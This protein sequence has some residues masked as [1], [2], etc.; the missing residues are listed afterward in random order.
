MSAATIILIFL[1]VAGAVA[2]VIAVLFLNSGNRGGMRFSG[3]GPT[4]G[5]SA[6][7]LGNIAGAVSRAAAG[8]EVP[9]DKMFKNRLR[10][11]GVFSGSILGILTARLWAMQINNTEYY[12]EQA[13]VNRT[14][15]IT[16]MAPRGRILD[17]NGNELVT[18]RPSLTV[19]A[20]SEVADN[21]TELNVLA[22]LLGMPAVAAKRK[23]QDSTV[24]AQS[25]R[26]VSVD[27]NRSSV[28]F[29]QEH[30][31]AF[32]GVSV[33]ERTQR[34]YP[35][36]ETACHVLGYTGTVTT[37]QIEESQNND[38]GIT[39]ENGDTTGQAGIE[40]QY[41]Q[42][43]QGV[44]GEQTVYVDANGNITNYSTSVPAESGSDIMLTIDL[45]LQQATEEALAGGIQRGHNADSECNS[46][47]A[48]VIDVTNGEVLA[49][50]SAPTFKPNLFV[51]GISQDDWDKL[52]DEK[53]GYP[54][55][56][57]AISGSYPAASTIKPLS[58]FAALDYGIATKDSWYNCPGWWTGFGEADGKYC[59]L[60][61]GHGGI[62]LRDGI[63]NSCDSVFYDIAKGFFYSDDQDGLQKTFRNWG[64]GSKTEIDLPSET[65]GRVPDADWKWNYFTDWSDDER[66]WNGG[67]ITNIVIGQGDIL[68][69][70]LQ[71]TCAYMGI[72]NSGTIWKPHLLKGVV[73]RSEANTMRE[74]SA[75]PHLQ[76]SES[77]EAYDLVHDALG[78]MAYEESESIALHFNN[79]SVR[80][81]AKT[82]T[83]EHGTGSA[84]AWMM[85][86]AP[87]DNPHYAIGATIEKGGYGSTSALYV[88]RDILGAIY[89][90]PDTYANV[91]ISSQSD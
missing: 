50:A 36:G 2:A 90:E 27:V 66:T 82:G 68:V 17:R 26:T 20:E 48:V 63:V 83:G 45:A 62:S 15:T 31:D 52:S 54:M 7:P 75:T 89:N 37:E 30:A 13:D 33:E 10:G 14:R 24:S 43:L 34:S 61:T 47:A 18:N 55:L 78:G 1:V 88:I 59:W 21:T 12:S 60:H 51:G 85:C 65:E 84:T 38:S 42:V 39:Y 71:M 28:A 32:S 69:T 58:T 79:L 76:P 4:G 53:E 74:V 5:G 41:E 40:Y 81:A 49:M 56:N 29:I 35:N 44:R 3:N 16:T 19:V 72:A 64:L 57:R 67:D 87:A 91:Q 8:K 46:G 25:A 80:V 9:P 6:S 22:N 70:T 77:Q 11:L 23:I 86:Y 73:G